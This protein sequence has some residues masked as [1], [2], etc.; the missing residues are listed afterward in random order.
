MWEE[1]CYSNKWKH[2]ATLHHPETIDG[3]FTVSGK[4]PLPPPRKL[5]PRK[6]PP[7]KLAPMKIPPYEYSPL[8]KLF[9]VKI[10]LKKFASKKIALYETPSPLINHT[11]KRKNK[12]TIFFA[13]KNAM[14][15][16][17]LIKI[18]KV[19]LDTQ[20]ISQKVRGL[21][22]FLTEW[23]KSKD[24]TKAKIAK[25]PLLASCTSHGELILGSQTIKFGK[26]VNY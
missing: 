11:N 4:L 24:W 20:M 8:W 9:P 1:L 14:Q 22:T 3:N 17:I 23:K 25:W 12:I 19:F 10:T 21:D 5:T 26:Y 13:L 7:R 18:T 6:F 2:L 15:H 16:N